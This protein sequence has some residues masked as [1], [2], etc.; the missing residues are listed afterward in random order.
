MKKLFAP[1]FVAAFAATAFAQ[2]PAPAAQSTEQGASTA[3]ASA[4]A[5]AAKGSGKHEKHEKHEK[6]AEKSTMAQ[7]KPLKARV[8]LAPSLRRLRNRNKSWKW[9]AKSALGR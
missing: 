6:K 9:G 8:V 1:L 3:A 2:T 7:P 4:A 5:P